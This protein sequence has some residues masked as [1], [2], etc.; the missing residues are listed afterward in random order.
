MKILLILAKKN[1]EKQKLNFS[2]S[3]RFHMKTRASLIYFV[4]DWLWKQFFASNSIQI[5]SD[6]ILLTILL[7]L[8]PFTQFQ[9]KITAIKLQESAKI[10][11][12]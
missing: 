6:L 2:R 9:S 8:R 5:P 1:L 4:N 12:T 11:F 7:T 10:C 3:A